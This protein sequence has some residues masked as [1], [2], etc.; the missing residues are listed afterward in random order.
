MALSL[1]FSKAPPSPRSAT[2][3]DI[4]V[5]PSHYVSVTFVVKP[6]EGSPK[7]IPIRL[8]GNTYSLGN[9]FADLRGGINDIAS[10]AP[11]LTTQEDGTYSLTLSLPVGIDLRYKYTLGDGFWN[12]ERS[13]NGGYHLRQLIVADHDATQSDKIDSWMSPGK[14]SITFTVTVPPSTSPNDVISI[15]FNPYGWTE[16]IPMWPMGD[17]K[18]IYILYNPLDLIGDSSY[19]YCRNDQ[20][21]T[22]DDAATDGPE[23]AGKPFSPSAEAQIFDD[24]VKE[25]AW[26]DPDPKPI[27]VTNNPIVTRPAGFFTGI[28]L[29][30]DYHPSWQPYYT[31]AF[32]NTQHDPLANCDHRSHLAL[33]QQ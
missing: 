8:V 25:W 29:F 30:G 10:R 24:S 23:A 13:E 19:R 9:T 28:E 5:N 1:L 7:G 6:P 20:C 21:G 33:H 17:N 26:I 16:P 2:P 31:W 14:G 15:Q 27:T 12:A 18:W 22:A 4:L 32:K 11:L 3:A